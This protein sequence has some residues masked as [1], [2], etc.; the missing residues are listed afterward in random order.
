MITTR[1]RAV[2]LPGA[3]FLWRE[4]TFSLI[5]SEY[6]SKLLLWEHRNVGAKA[7]I[8]FFVASSDGDYFFR[9]VGDS[10]IWQRRFNVIHRVISAL[11]YRHR[12][13][14]GKCTRAGPKSTCS[15]LICR[16]GSFSIK[17]VRMCGN[18]LSHSDLHAAR[19]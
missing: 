19:V 10:S 14:F 17:I 1:W 5:S 16:R 7:T 6:I 8:F 3:I 12:F 2:A 4:V 15:C 9:R 11:S 13:F 18:Q